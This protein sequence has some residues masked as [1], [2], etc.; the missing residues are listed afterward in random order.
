MLV[1]LSWLQELVPALA[2]RADD[3]HDLAARLTRAG[4]A[5]E[6]V[7]TVGGGVTG[8]VVTGEVLGLVPEPQRNGKTVRWCS[9]GVGEAEPR[10]IVCGADNL[11]VG[12]RVV[13][14]L[15]GA[16]LPG[17]FTIAARKTYGHVS[18][19]MICSARELGLGTDHAGILVLDAATPVGADA[20]ALL[21][22][23]AETVLDIAV[24]PDRGYALSLRGVAR[25]A[26]TAYDVA[27][28]DPADVPLDPADGPGHPVSVR[29]IAACPRYV[30]RVVTGLDPAA[31]TPPALARRLTA[32]G[33]RSISLAVDVTNLVLLG[34]GQPL[35][36]FDRGRLR[37][38][39]VVRRAR[40]GER[41]R[42]LDGVDRELVAED[43][44]I[45]DDSGPVALA[46]V[47]GGA[48]TEVTAATTEVLLEAACFDAATV[49]GT[50]R[51][52][53]LASEA[54]RRF[55]RGV[56][57]ALAP[58][59]A[60]SAVDLLVALG[61][62]TVSPGVT[63]VD[64]R[65]PP[66]AVPM[67]VGAAAQKAGRDYDRDTV[68]RRLTDVG[69]AVTGGTEGDAAGDEATL[70]V[71]PPSWRPD[72]TGEADLVE[73]VVRLE[74]YETIPSVLPR[75]PGGRGLTEAQRLRRAVG[76]A[77]AH[78]GYVE[79]VT[80]PFLAA[81]DLA[82]LGLP[83][84]D[85][86]HHA[87]RVVNPLTA[88]ADRLRTTLLPGLLAAAARNVNRG[89][90]D[91]ALVEIGSVFRPGPAGRP[92]APRLGVAS[93]PS[94]ADRKALDAALPD[95]PLRVGVLITGLRALPSW[96][97]DGRPAGWSD[98]VAAARTVAATAGVELRVTADAHAP[99]H[100]GRCAALWAGEVL[101]GHAG[102]LHPSVAER[103]GLPVGTAAAELDLDRLLAARPRTA[104]RA[105]R[106]SA[107]PPVLR[108]VALVVPATVAAADVAE[109]L[110]AGAGGL[111]ESLR[112]FD[113]YTGAG[114]AE[115]AV[116]LAYR[117]TLRAPDRTLTDAE[118]NAVR[119][120]AVAAAQERTGAVLRT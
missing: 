25:E 62:A 10:G 24:T 67:R 44:V 96:S 26:A 91:L 64:H 119:D 94:E 77:L 83:D 30:A 72:L 49:A 54:G 104:V 57:P 102:E 14:A 112:L 19:G 48:A 5:V 3:A 11:A 15:P 113:R 108:D 51:R 76:R 87:T 29:D 52:H 39:V 31:P 80:P 21:D 55:E 61:G 42:T 105:P 75:A 88:D 18:D 74:G 78:A 99:W 2:G 13:V 17:G 9:V 1:P 73:E 32:A 35:H 101:L 60:Q 63:D 82:A 4:L 110:L 33:M 66:R 65:T 106:V 47:M 92:P 81:A 45:A 22:L 71:V 98:A 86:R 103:H 23:Q 79:V 36:A 7:H 58:A 85:D 53:G 70:A 100:P 20:V 8:P 12:D 89:N 50:A 46:G 107:Y 111:L 95:Q 34:L 16:V 97:G 41:L 117:L 28:S 93:A 115:G 118:A 27:F 6:G 38:A 90:R 109:A 43:L 56:D 116:S 59:A 37:G 84:S 114:V 40:A 69:C 120:A 68:V